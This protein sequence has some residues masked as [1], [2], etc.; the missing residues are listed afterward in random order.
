M[1]RFSRFIS[2][3]TLAAALGLGG[4]A[5]A[6]PASAAPAGLSA[7]GAEASQSRQVE[8]V[9]WVRQCR[10]Q[11]VTRRDRYGHRVRVTREV[12]RRVWV[13]PPRHYR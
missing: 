5:F 3:C 8:D 2:S 13:G 4:L 11:R 6:Q 10:P 1:T 9:R 12:C 7:L